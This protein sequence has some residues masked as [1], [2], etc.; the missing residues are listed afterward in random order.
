VSF[1]PGTVFGEL[2]ILDSRARSA[3]VTSD[4]GLA[5]YVLAT[6]GFAALSARSPAVALKLAANLGRELS[7]RL[8]A[9]NRTIQQL[10][11]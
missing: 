1:A 5:C 2:A 8:R 3:T 6:K 4:A 11:E 9:A 10:E 7:H